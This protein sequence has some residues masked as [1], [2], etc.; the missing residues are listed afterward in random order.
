MKYWSNC[1]L[2]DF[3]KIWLSMLLRLFEQGQENH[4]PDVWQKDEEFVLDIVDFADTPMHLLY[5]GI[6]K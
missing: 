4:G 6:K 3:Q 5:L 1:K 2:V